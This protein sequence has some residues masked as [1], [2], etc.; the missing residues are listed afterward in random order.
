MSVGKSELTIFDK[1]NP[2]VVIERTN[3]VEYSPVTALNSN[4]PIDFLIVSDQYLD[5]S[6]SLLYVRFKLNDGAGYSVAVVN[7]ILSSAFADIEVTMDEKIVE[8]T[9]HLYPYKSMFT[10]LLNYNADAKNSTLAT[11]GY[12]EDQAGKMDDATNTGFVKRK[13]NTNHEYVGPLWL[14]TFN[15]SRF[16][17]PNVKIGIK[18][19]PSRTEFHL[20]GIKDATATTHTSPQLEIEECK[21]YIRNVSVNP[22]VRI[23]HEVGLKSENAIYPFQRSILKNFAVSQGLSNISLDNIFNQKIPKM[24]VFCM[25]GNQAFNGT[26]KSN[27]FNFEHF[28]C[29]FIGLYKDGICLPRKEFA[30]DFK[31]GKCVREYV[32]MMQ[33]LNMFSRNQTNSISFEEYKKGGYQLF[34]Y[35]LAADLS[36]SSR[37]PLTIGNIR[38]DL[39]FS[40]A[41]PKA[42]NIVMMGL[43]DDEIQITESRRVLL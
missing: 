22:T 9:N 10:I 19:T 42:I 43:F 3:W 36:Y 12:F 37:Q 15:Q 6:E 21:I 29:N 20:Q 17:I 11:S 35:N 34:V 39:R 31:N 40:T 2:Q 32:A 30:P 7:N 16:I 13:E 27:P 8:S 1:V 25:V 24:I 4:S 41:L 28:D 26:L 33:N 18:L 14:D 38:L 5:L 23:A